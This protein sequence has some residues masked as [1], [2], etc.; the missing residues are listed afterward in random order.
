[1]ILGPITT[2][3]FV[4]GFNVAQ[5][6]ISESDITASNLPDDVKN[7]IVNNAPNAVTQAELLHL[8]ETQFKFGQ[9]D[10]DADES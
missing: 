4:V 10:N 3:G 1:M 8:F 5:S 2:S 6:F 9:V 7:R